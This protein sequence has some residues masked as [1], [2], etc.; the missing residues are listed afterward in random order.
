MPALTL[1]TQLL[2][3]PEPAPVF[4]GGACPKI[5]PKPKKQQHRGGADNFDIHS[6]API[7]RH[8]QI[9]PAQIRGL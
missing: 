7:P 5:P 8:R 6:V 4:V 2:E 3:L 9:T 1:A